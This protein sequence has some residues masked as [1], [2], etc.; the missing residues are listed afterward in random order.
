M[1]LGQRVRAV[2]SDLDM[3]LIDTKERFYNLFNELLREWMGRSVSRQV[4]EHYA[5]WDRLNELIG[6]SDEDA[7][8]FWK[9]FLSRYSKRF[10]AKPIPGARECLEQLRSIGVSVIVATGRI[11]PV[12]AVLRELDRLGM[13]DLVDEVVTKAHTLDFGDGVYSKEKMVSVAVSRV[14][15]SPN[16][17]I[18]VGD[19]LDDI[20]AGKRLGAFTVGVLTGFTHRSLLEREGADAVID[21]VAELPSVL[22][23]GSSA[24]QQRQRSL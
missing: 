9:E 5:R 14:G 3:T 22:F 23:G 15:C 4:F 16:Q 11:S 17:C 10:D 13:S 2:V 12:E 7:V 1:P 20:R 6:L 24:S 21:S 19:Y 8:P 18:V